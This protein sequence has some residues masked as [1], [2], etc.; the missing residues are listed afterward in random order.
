MARIA[1]KLFD[2]LRGSVRGVC[3]DASTERANA[4]YALLTQASVVTRPAASQAVAADD[5]RD[6]DAAT[7]FAEHNDA[8]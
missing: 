2:R 1:R 4:A 6:Q 7:L 5:W 3:L 8:A